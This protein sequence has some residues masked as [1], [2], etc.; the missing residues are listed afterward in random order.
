MRGNAGYESMAAGRRCHTRAVNGSRRRSSVDGLGAKISDTAAVPGTW[1]CEFEV[2]GDALLT[3]VVDPDNDQRLAR[4][5]VRLHGEPFG[6][7]TLPLNATAVDEQ[8]L[9]HA[10]WE[11]FADTINAHLKREGLAAVKRLR[12]DERPASASE[13]CANAVISDAFVSAVVCTRN[14]SEVLAVCLQYLEG[15]TY[16]YLEVIVVDNAPSDDSTRRVVEAAASR[17]SRFRYVCEPRAGLSCARNRGLLAARGIYVAYTDDDV[18]VDSRWID[19]L[20]RGFQRDDSAA[21]VTGI[22]CSAS[23]MN[24]AEAYFDARVLSW[25]TRF[26]SVVYDLDRSVAADPLAPYSAGKF[27]TGANFAFDRNCLNE[28]GAFDEALGAGTHTRGGEDLDMFIRV[29]NSGRAIVYE[30]AAVVWHRHRADDT[31]LLR[32]MY[33]YG[34]GLSALIA[35]YLVQRSTRMDVLRRIGAGLPRVMAIRSST[36]ARL[37]AGVQRP[38]GAMRRELAGFAVGPLLYLLAMRTVRDHGRMVAQEH[39]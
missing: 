1:C 8:A 13:R 32:Q 22:V 6:Y 12:L 25:S 20:L 4:V 21:C 35:K 5:L 28:L 30:P 3:A 36:A 34:T 10:V 16:P 9:L 24:A 11:Q 19:G 14:R 23:I 7:V 29:L 39:G 27:G 18:S 2:S 37:G 17:D 38:S 15:L 26:R 31:A 33:G